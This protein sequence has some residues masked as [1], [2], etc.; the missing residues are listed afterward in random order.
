MPKQKTSDKLKKRFKRLDK[1][2]EK[3]RDTNKDALGADYTERSEY[4]SLKFDIDT[5]QYKL[6]TFKMLRYEELKKKYG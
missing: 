6:P 3:N 1:I 4:L 2:K 5:G